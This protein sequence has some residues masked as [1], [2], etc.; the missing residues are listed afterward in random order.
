MDT[1]IENGKVI[2]RL[3]EIQ[4]LPRL[5][6]KS[7]AYIKERAKSPKQPFSSMCHSVRRTPRSCPLKKMAGQNVNHIVV[8]EQQIRAVHLLSLRIIDND[9]NLPHPTDGSRNG[10]TPLSP[11]ESLSEH[12]TQKANS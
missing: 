2:E 6:E 11:H 7:V 12:L 5:T 3:N 8:N 1:I 4:N 9:K 10:A